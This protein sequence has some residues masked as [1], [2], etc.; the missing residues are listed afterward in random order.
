MLSQFLMTLFTNHLQVL[1]FATWK[2]LNLTPEPP[3]PSAQTQNI[4]SK[5]C[6]IAARGMVAHLLYLGFLSHRSSTGGLSIC[7][8]PALV[9]NPL[10]PVFCALYHAS[11]AVEEK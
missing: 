11:E 3:C 2:T 4:S 8:S 10:D 1:W 9:N 7:S 5:D 6:S